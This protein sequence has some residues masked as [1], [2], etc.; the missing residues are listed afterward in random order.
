[1]LSDNFHAMI[2]VETIEKRG[3]KTTTRTTTSR[4]SI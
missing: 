3:S 1:L 2:K 4:S